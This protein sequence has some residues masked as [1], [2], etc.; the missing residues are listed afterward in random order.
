MGNLHKVQAQEWQW[1]ADLKLDTVPKEQLALED[2][3]THAV[4]KD[5][6]ETRVQLQSVEEGVH[7]RHDEH[8]AVLREIRAY[9]LQQDKEQSAILKKK[10]ALAEKQEDFNLVLIGFN[11]LLSLAAQ[12]GSVTDARVSNGPGYLF[13]KMVGHCCEGLPEKSVPRKLRTPRTT[14]LRITRKTSPDVIDL[15][16]SAKLD[17][18]C[19]KKEGIL[20]SASIPKR[21]RR[22]PATTG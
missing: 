10:A 2:S 12:V 13:K 7:E 4:A 11:R 19:Q 16:M 6:N 3:I 9:Q 21:P 17:K 18:T 15:M 20:E 8:Q 5:G 14:R 1:K 22:P